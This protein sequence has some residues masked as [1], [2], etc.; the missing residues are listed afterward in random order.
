M[1]GHRLQNITPYNNFSQISKKLHTQHQQTNN[2]K[3]KQK[4][5]RT[6]QTK[7]NNKP[8]TIQQFFVVL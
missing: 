1:Q 7:Q 6:K 3:Q 5:K 2:Y 4:Q 8:V